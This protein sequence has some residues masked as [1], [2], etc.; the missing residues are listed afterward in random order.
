[1]VPTAFNYDFFQSPE[2][3]LKEWLGVPDAVGDKIHFA[4]KMGEGWVQNLNLEPGAQ[5]RLWRFTCL[6]ELQTK[7]EE[8]DFFKTVYFTVYYFLSGKPENI[9]L[10]TTETPLFVRIP[11]GKTQMMVICITEP[12]LNNLF[13]ETI[14]LLKQAA[15]AAFFGKTKGRIGTLTPTDYQLLQEL[16]Q[17]VEQNKTEPYYFKARLTILLYQL[18]NLCEHKIKEGLEITHSVHE[19]IMTEIAKRLAQSASGNF[20]GL[21]ELAKEF[22]MSS[23]TL[24]RQFKL[25]NGTTIYQYYLT[26]KMEHAKELLEGEKKISEVAYLLGYENVS[27]FIKMFKKHYGVSPGSHKSH[28]DL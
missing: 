16:F 7:I 4:N 12:W 15:E 23:S 3:E 1:M 22:N 28:P 9:L 13:P 11:E 8:G 21:E 20:P 25:L 2:K 17:K 18:F 24:K 19:N 27:H 6:E 26:R 5:L 10:F 14:P